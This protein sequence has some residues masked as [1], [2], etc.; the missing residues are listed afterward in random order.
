[1]YFPWRGMIQLSWGLGRMRREERGERREEEEDSGEERERG[2][3]RDTDYRHISAALIHFY[4]ILFH[5]LKRRLSLNTVTQTNDS[6]SLR[7]PPPPHLVCK[8]V[9]YIPVPSFFSLF[10]FI[11]RFILFIVLIWWYDISR[12]FSIFENKMT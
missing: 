3:E 4:D 8:I 1:M 9:M 7:P 10:S 2:R 6:A 11:C 12:K 5:I